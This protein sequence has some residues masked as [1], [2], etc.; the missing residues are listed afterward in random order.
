M[1]GVCY[2]EKIDV[3]EKEGEEEKNEWV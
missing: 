1:F 2:K 3:D